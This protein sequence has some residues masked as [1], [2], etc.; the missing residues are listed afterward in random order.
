MAMGLQDRNIPME[1]YFRTI[2]E[3]EIA[4][5]H[6]YHKSSDE[7]AKVSRR[8][9]EINAELRKTPASDTPVVRAEYSELRK[10]AEGLQDDMDWIK[11]IL[12]RAGKLTP[13]EK[14]TEWEVTLRDMV[15]L[16][17]KPKQKAPPLKTELPIGDKPEVSNPKHKGRGK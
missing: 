2:R 9:G 16:G 5:E 17:M 8:V 3:I 6:A 11:N 1:F 12:E 13:D 7:L 14:A 4:A 15:R 10:K